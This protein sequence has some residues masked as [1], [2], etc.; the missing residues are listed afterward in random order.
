MSQLPRPFQMGVVG[1]SDWNLV[2]ARNVRIGSE[3]PK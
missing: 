1:Q 2:V 3:P